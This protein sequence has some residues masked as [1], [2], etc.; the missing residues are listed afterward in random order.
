MSSRTLTLKAFQELYNSAY[1]TLDRACDD[2]Q[3]VCAVVGDLDPMLP[4]FSAC[5][6]MHLNAAT[7]RAQA[8]HAVSAALQFASVAASI[9]ALAEVAEASLAA[10]PVEATVEAARPPKAKRPKR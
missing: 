6:T 2:L 9:Q 3:S 4:D 5:A 7:L 8:N 1:A 10:L